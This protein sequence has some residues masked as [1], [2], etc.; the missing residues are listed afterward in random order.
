MQGW[1]LSALR[2]AT[3]SN[4]PLLPSMHCA[5]NFVLEF[6]SINSPILTLMH[7]RAAKL[8][9]CSTDLSCLAA[10]VISFWN[11]LADDKFGAARACA[12]VRIGEFMLGNSRM[13]YP[14][15]CMLGRRG[16]FEGVAD[17]L[18]V[19]PLCVPHSLVN[20]ASARQHQRTLV[21]N[22]KTVASVYSASNYFVGLKT[23]RFDRA[24]R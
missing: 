1:P 6:P 9:V 8:V 24:Y 7:A 21:Q 12:T 4:W 2:K 14:M 17:W 19:L 13:N 15:Q 18:P 23:C 22:W 20:T 11:F 16:Q 3:P 10:W 5:G